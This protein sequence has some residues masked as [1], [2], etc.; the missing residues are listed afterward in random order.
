MHRQR[1]ER[2]DQS[3][4]WSVFFRRYWYGFV[5][6]FAALALLGFWYLRQIQP[7]TVLTPT[8]PASIPKSARQTRQGMVG[9]VSSST[10]SK[11]EMKQSTTVAKKAVIWVDV[12]GA[13]NQPGV[14]QLAP[15]S[16]LD[17]A[18]RMAGGLTGNAD[19]RQVNLAQSLTDG[20]AVY[21]PQQGELGPPAASA[22]SGVPAASATSGPADGAS[23][24]PKNLNSVSQAELEEISGIGPKRAQEIIAYRESHGPFQSVDDL[25]EISG[26]GE[27]TIANLKTAL[28]V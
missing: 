11:Q 26:I 6:V 24:A 1:S 15:G 3:R 21:I 19:R 8:Q 25:K 18:V 20:T 12:Q 16:R 2:T 4:G 17:H 27:K 14:Y 7:A 22:S 9:Q 28:T 5:G 10:S 13:V 23:K